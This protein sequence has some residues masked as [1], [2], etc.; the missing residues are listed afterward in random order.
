MTSKQSGV[1]LFL[2]SSSVG[3]IETHVMQLARG[4]VSH[5]I[6]VTL[7]LYQAYPD[8]PIP[9]LLQQLAETACDGQLTLQIL[10]GRPHSLHR[11]IRTG[12]RPAVLHTHGY[13]AGLIGRFTGR[14]LG[15]PVA[16][17]WHAGEVPAGIVRVYDFLDRYTAPLAH[18]RFAVSP[19]IQ[20]R[21]PSSSVVMDNFVD[22]DS[23]V[24][25]NG[26]QLAFVGR[27]SHEKGPDIFLQLARQLPP[28][29]FHMYGGGDMAQELQ[30]AAPD[31]LT[32]HGMQTDMASVWERIGLLIMPSRYEGLP[33]AV[34]EAMARGIPVLASNVGALPSVIQSGVNGW[35]VPA[36]DPDA[37][38]E[39]LQHWFSLSAQEKQV[40][41]SAARDTIQKRFSA[42][43]IIP[44]F[45]RAY[46]SIAPDLCPNTQAPALSSCDDT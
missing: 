7:V 40:I 13:K 6:D 4:L 3:G 35:L 24:R 10:D 15:V 17:T 12:P 43:A 42:T 29:N 11:L 39:A 31:N 44:E 33:M 46:Q 45:L 5:G 19:Q 34:L 9:Q 25:S 32:L 27:L 2:D 30:A 18:L 20:A 1:W 16:S 23:I 37:F 41:Q 36:A 28:H 14:L 21:L 22:L 38:T 8:S 26:Q